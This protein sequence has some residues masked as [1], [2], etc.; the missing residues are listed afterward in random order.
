[1]NTNAD[2]RPAI[3][4]DSIEFDRSV[5]IE[6]NES[7]ADEIC[8]FTEAGL[9]SLHDGKETECLYFAINFRD[10]SG[11]GLKNMSVSFDDFLQIFDAESDEPLDIMCEFTPE[12]TVTDRNDDGSYTLLLPIYVREACEDDDLLTKL[13]NDNALFQINGVEFSNGS[14]IEHIDTVLG[15]M[16]SDGA[17]D[18]E[19]EGISFKNA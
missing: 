9:T 19:C 10:V 14:V 15:A 16:T 5:E 6:G 3:V 18:I 2:I 4:I 7:P 13:Q 17:A 12:F 8:Y 11:S 1:M